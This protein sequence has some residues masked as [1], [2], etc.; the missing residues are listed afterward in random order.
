MLE[1]LVFVLESEAKSFVTK[2]FFIVFSIFLL[3]LLII[4]RVVVVVIITKLRV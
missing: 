4:R 3:F 2:G 1:Y